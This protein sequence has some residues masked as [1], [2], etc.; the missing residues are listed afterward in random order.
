[1]NREFVIYPEDKTPKMW[2]GARAMN[3]N[4]NRLNSR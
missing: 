4:G 2:W 3:M 1:M